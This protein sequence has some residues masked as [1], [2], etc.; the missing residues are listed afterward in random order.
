M[1]PGAA[2][3]FAS[4]IGLD[5][6]ASQVW[7]EHL[8]ATSW[9]G[10]LVGS[11]RTAVGFGGIGLFQT[12]AMLTLL[13]PCEGSYYASIIPKSRE[14]YLPKQWQWRYPA[15]FTMNDTPLVAEL[16]FMDIKLRP[17][18]GLLLPPHTYISLSPES[19][20][21]TTY[22]VIE[23]HEPISMLASKN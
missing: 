9:V 12:S 5:V 6:W 13:I 19:T 3:Q 21:L 23:Y 8:L 10:N 20:A 15:T 7:K 17:G 14:V 1:T 16:A 2:R 18:T 4:E 22:V 11:I